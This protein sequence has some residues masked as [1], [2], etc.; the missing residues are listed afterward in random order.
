MKLDLFEKLIRKIIREELEFYN[1]KLINEIKQT[2][3]SQP[4]T[5]NSLIAG[6][7]ENIF[8]TDN[9]NLK[10]GLRSFRNE[11]AAQYG[12]EENESISF[13]NAEIPDD[14]KKVFNR[15]Y[16]ELMKKLK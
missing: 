4:S 10:E 5:G 12:N 11:L 13:G 16:S 1:S 14:L 8:T 3:K 6:P 15:D 9:V 2:T 7:G